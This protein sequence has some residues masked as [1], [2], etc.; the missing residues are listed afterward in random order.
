VAFTGTPTFTRIGTNTLVITGLSLD[1]ST[2]GNIGPF[3][4]VSQVQMPEGFPVYDLAAVP[5]YMC[6][7]CTVL[8]EGE[9]DDAIGPPAV[10]VLDYNSETPNQPL[11]TISNVS[12][13]FATPNMRITIRFPHSLPR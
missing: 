1:A 8:Y 6:M 2:D 11:F 5:L 7:D 10:Y 12:P 13:D 9:P 4:S 3:G